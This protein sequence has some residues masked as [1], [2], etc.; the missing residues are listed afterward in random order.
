MLSCKSCWLKKDPN[1]CLCVFNVAIHLL[2]NMSWGQVSYTYPTFSLEFLLKCGSLDKDIK[3]T[4]VFIWN[5][6]SLLTFAT[7]A[8]SNIFFY[9]LYIFLNYFCGILFL[10]VFNLNYSVILS[11]LLRLLYS[12]KNR[13]S[14]YAQIIFFF[15]WRG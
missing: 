5:L 11:S 2:L 1:S 3:L 8:A 10:A 6:F 13:E 15:F 4:N 7:T 9:C 12:A 14:H